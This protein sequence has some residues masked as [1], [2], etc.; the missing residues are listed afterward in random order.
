MLNL[1]A[2]QVT[3]HTA[4]AKRTELSVSSVPAQ[5]DMAGARSPPASDSSGAGSS[6]RSPANGE[7]ESL[8]VESCAP[9]SDIIAEA[10]GKHPPAEAAAQVQGS[11]M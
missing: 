8:P 1:V 3:R 4:P 2:A 9:V 6:T 5:A 11:L 10:C 7:A